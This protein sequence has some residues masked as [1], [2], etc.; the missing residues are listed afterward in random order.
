L[1]CHREKLLSLI[2]IIFPEMSTHKDFQRIR[3][4][5]DVPSSPDCDPDS[6]QPYAFDEFGT[7]TSS[8]LH[9]ESRDDRDDEDVDSC[10]TYSESFKGK[11][12]CT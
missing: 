9:D 1:N 6:G 10:S 12:Y 3:I 8:G 11:F 2:A 7:H 5:P 4:I